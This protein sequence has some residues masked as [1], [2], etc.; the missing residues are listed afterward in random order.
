VVSQKAAAWG[1]PDAPKT[2]LT[3]G[4]TRVDGSPG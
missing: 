2:K 4:H 3:D 1:V